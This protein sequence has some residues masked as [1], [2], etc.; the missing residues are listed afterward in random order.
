[1]MARINS[2]R[3]DLQAEVARRGGRIR[4]INAIDEKRVHIDVV[5]IVE[6]YINIPIIASP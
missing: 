3:A 6:T 5:A 1:M 4:R 2:R